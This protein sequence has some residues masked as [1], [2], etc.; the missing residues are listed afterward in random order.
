[1]TGF[2]RTFAKVTDDVILAEDFNDEFQALE[3]AFSNTTGHVH[4]GSVANGAY[5]PLISDADNSN[6]IQIDSTNNEIEFYTE[7]ATVKTAQMVLQDGKLL[8][9]VDNDIDLGSA[10]F[11]FKDLYIDGT[12][13][14]D[15]LLVD[16]FTSTG[17]DDNSTAE[18]LQ[19]AD[20]IADW[21]QA[22]SV[23]TLA[24]NV[25]DQILYLSGG[26][27][28][29]SGGNII[30]Y[31]GTHTT[32]AGDLNLRSA[33]NTFFKWDESA[34]SLTLSTGTGAKTTALTL[35]SSQNATFTGDIT[36]NGGVAV[37]GVANSYNIDGI[38]TE[39]DTSISK[40]L[41]CRSG[42]NYS[43]MTFYTSGADS[44]GVVKE[45]M[46]IDSS[47]NVG[48]GTS[49]PVNV[50]HV[51]NSNPN[52][53]LESTNGSSSIYAQ[54]YTDA[55]GS[56]HLL[57]DTGNAAASTSM[58][59]LVDANEAMRI[60]SSG[61]VGIGTSSPANNL[62]I[63]KSELVGYTAAATG[64][65]ILEDANFAELY[66]AGAQ[67]SNILF[68]DAASNGVGQLTYVHN[69]DSMRFRVNTAERMRIDSSGNVGIGTSSPAFKLSVNGNV[70]LGGIAPYIAFNSDSS[71][72]AT[73]TYMQNNAATG[74]FEIVNTGNGS[75]GYF[76]F[77][78][79]SNSEAMRIDSSGNVG[80]GVIPTVNLDVKKTSAGDVFKLTGSTDGGRPL[81]FSSADN[82]IYLGAIW[83]RDIESAS[84]IHKW[85]ISGTE[86][87]RIDS[88]GNLCIGVTSAY[89]GYKLSTYGWGK[90]RHPSAD[91][92]VAIVSGSTTAV[93]V[94]AF[95]DTASDQ[96]G[97]IAYYH[98]NDSMRFNTVASERM[99]IDSSGNVLVG[100]TTP[101]GTP[102]YGGVYIAGDRSVGSP[103]SYAQLFI[104]HSSSTNHGLVIKELVSSGGNAVIFLNSSG[105]T[106]G[107]ISTTSSATAYNTS[108]DYRL[109]EDWQPMTDATT[110]LMSLNPVN[111]AWKA[112]GSRVDGFIA[113]EAQVVVPEAVTGE[114]DAVDDE[115]NPKYQGIDQ[116]K[117]VPL[118][119]KALQEAMERIETLEAKVAALE[120]V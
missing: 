58:R 20:T 71:S 38:V 109:K 13:N 113:H 114:K 87:M 92:Q 83:D 9:A 80:I 98:A 64:G 91:S 37:T 5:V 67:T 99:R 68:G 29:S 39:Y 31:G 16:S 115:G 120:S 12:A 104:N 28:A 69:D 59:F 84:G 14:I 63:R 15:T 75:N 34:G 23:Y 65:M 70:A 18:A 4:D 78:V 102:T 8:P 100:L 86:A 55:S 108:S 66:L 97:V 24:R 51:K 117:L 79:G 27:S 21:G 72:L 42:G 43:E 101:T 26:S 95:G 77:N 81:V 82:G 105:T 50:V 74:E 40:L 116:S 85:S 118:L 49:A 25:D 33:T 10:S 90:F 41:A 61:N 119:T 7:V 30:L 2:T 73:P 3:D 44:S 19:L 107:S 17:I 110:R 32:G 47:G 54:V 93:S 52:I 56:L 76:T 111:F 60:A 62:H 53:R 46:R 112:D 106:I 6:A 45:R 11:E 22:G 57:A 103:N 1:M 96:A 36:V 88:S 35:D 94:L 48:I 89:S